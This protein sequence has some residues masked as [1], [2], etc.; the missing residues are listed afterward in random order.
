M[1]TESKFNMKNAIEFKDKINDENINEDEKLASFG[2]VSLFPIPLDLA[3]TNIKS[4]GT[5][6]QQH[7]EIPDQTFLE[8]VKI[9]S[10]ENRR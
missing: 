1:T 4:K 8:I 5:K 9:C 2:V 10:V 6:I 7:T 3:L